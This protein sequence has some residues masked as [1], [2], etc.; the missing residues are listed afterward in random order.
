MDYLMLGSGRAEPAL[1]EIDG[2]RRGRGRL[3]E[4]VGGSR[5]LMHL[6]PRHTMIDAPERD[7]WCKRSVFDDEPRSAARRRDIGC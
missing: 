1:D 7:V 4:V 6:R 3:D 2:V 5:E